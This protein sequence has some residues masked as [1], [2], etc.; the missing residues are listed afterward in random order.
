MSIVF[1][2]VQLKCE[3]FYLKIILF[4]FHRNI[5]FLRR[6][7][8]R[9]NCVTERMEQVLKEQIELDEINELLENSDEREDGSTEVAENDQSTSENDDAT[10]ETELTDAANGDTQITTQ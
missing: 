5:V 8:D 3:K 4:R 7:S 9:F 1:T 10:I 2:K 6:N